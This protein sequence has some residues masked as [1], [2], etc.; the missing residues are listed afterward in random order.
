MNNIEKVLSDNIE[1]VNHYG[2]QKQMTIW[3]EEMSELTKEICKWNRKY[4]KFE[5]DIPYNELNNIKDEITD[6]TICLDQMKYAICFLED[7]L[8]NRYAQK[9]ERQHER[10]K[11]GE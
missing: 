5:G 7:E 9:V 2:I 4:E 10:I 8:M 1:I 6:V 3:I 11:K